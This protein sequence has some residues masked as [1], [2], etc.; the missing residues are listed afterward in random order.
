MLVS[1]YAWQAPCSCPCFLSSV[2]PALSPLRPLHALRAPRA[3][4]CRSVGEDVETEV[5][6]NT[7]DMAM[8]EFGGYCALT[9]P[10]T[11][12]T[13][14]VL[15]AATC[16]STEEEERVTVLMHVLPPSV[17][18]PGL[19]FQGKGR[20]AERAQGGQCVRGRACLPAQIGNRSLPACWEVVPCRIRSVSARSLRQ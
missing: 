6:E 20:A 17:P 7:M 3:V 2:V 11:G 5:L 8:M 15:V 18:L 9:N 12:I 4:L 10:I 19:S 14:S 13:K 1:T 16:S